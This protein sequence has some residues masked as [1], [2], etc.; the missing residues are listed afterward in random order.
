MD[1]H[2][3]GPR[4][5]PLLALGADMGAT[6]DDEGLALQLLSS[7]EPRA[8]RLGFDLAGSMAS[9]ALAG[10]LAALSRDPRPE[11]RLA[12]LAALAGAGD[13]RA[14]QR[15]A[16]EVRAGLEASD[17]AVRNAA[18]ESVRAGDSFAVAPAIAM[19]G[20]ARTADAAAGAVG[21]LGDAVV[22]S[23]AELLEGAGS[24]APVLAMRLVRADSTQSVARDEVLRRH[25]AHPDRELALAV[26]ERLV[27]LDPAPDTTAV[28]LDNRLREDVRRAALV[29]AALAAFEPRC[30]WTEPDR[31][32]TPARASRRARSRLPDRQGQPA[33]SSRIGATWFGADRTNG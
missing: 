12:A 22:P 17:V 20:D 7:P 15:I 33:C 24:P 23:M 18:L 13:E 10:E 6:V 28:A 27:A 19:L 1:R 9:P 26:A 2:S 31:R 16:D 8:I 32:A 14:E 25:L 30:N 5:R 4:R 21:R 3:S 11:I 29:L